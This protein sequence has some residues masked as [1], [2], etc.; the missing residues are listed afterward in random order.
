MTFAHYEAI[1]EYLSM[2]VFSTKCFRPKLGNFL[3]KGKPLVREG[4]KATDPQKKVGWL[5]YQNMEVN[6]A[7]QIFHAICIFH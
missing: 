1:I 2:A 4:H 7:T 6:H 3:E 5:R